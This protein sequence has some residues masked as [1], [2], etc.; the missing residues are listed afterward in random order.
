MA[1]CADLRSDSLYRYLS[2]FFQELFDA[3]VKRSQ[4]QLFDGRVTF[5]DHMLQR[6]TIG[7]LGISP[8]R[9]RTAYRHL[10]CLFVIAG[11]GRFYVSDDRTGAGAREVAN[12]PGDLIIVRA[13]GFQESDERPFHYFVDIRSTRYV[14]GL[15]HDQTRLSGN[16]QP[17]CV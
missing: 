5:N 6:Y 7:E 12:A 3:A 4:R 1:V 13:P 17:L 9:D 11:Y 16:A 15:R 2:A 14:F 8:H 10:I